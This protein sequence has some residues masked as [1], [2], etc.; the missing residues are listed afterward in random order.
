MP[1]VFSKADEGQILQIN[2]AV[3]NALVEIQKDKV[4]QIITK[5]FGSV[6]QYQKQMQ[7]YPQLSLKA[8]QQLFEKLLTLVLDKL[9]TPN[10]IPKVQKLYMGFYEVKQL[11]AVYLTSF[12]FKASSFINKNNATNTVHLS[13]RL[14][15]V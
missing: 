3:L 1:E 2:T 10:L 4:Q 11:E 7:L 9:N 8:D 15:V 6:E 12:L 14:K 5:S 13:H